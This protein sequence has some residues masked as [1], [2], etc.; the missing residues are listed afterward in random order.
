MTSRKLTAQILVLNMFFFQTPLVFA[1]Q[2]IILTDAELDAVHAGGLNLTFERAV[3]SQDQLRRD[4]NNPYEITVQP[5]NR[6]YNTSTNSRVRVNTSTRR[7]SSPV[8]PAAPAAPI[9]PT[10]PD[11]SSL[12][13]NNNQISS[14]TNTTNIPISTSSVTPEPNAPTNL[15]STPTDLAKDLT[16]GDPLDISAGSL[17]TSPDTSVANDPAN[18][19]PDL[20]LNSAQTDV[21]ENSLPISSP[22]DVDTSTVIDSTITDTSVPADL[23]SNPTI[24]MDVISNGKTLGSNIGI[25]PNDASSVIPLASTVGNQI[26]VSETAQQNLS[27]LTNINNAGGAV[28][29][30]VNLVFLGEGAVVENLNMNNSLNLSNVTNHTVYQQ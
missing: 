29:V 27:A 22:A 1:G 2:G 8:A 17:N 20:A 3:G 23:T 7:P 19:S 25:Q 26:N 10:E 6:Y 13:T 15:T 4:L 30:L 28:G 12:P 14:S 21:V 18:I 16:G 9:A 5:T 11:L 24:V